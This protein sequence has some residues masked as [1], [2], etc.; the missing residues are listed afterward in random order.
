M[1][2]LGESLGGD[3]SQ[4]DN[5]FDHLDAQDQLNAEYGAELGDI[6]AEIAAKK[7]QDRELGRQAMAA[8]A[9]AP[10]E[11]A[12][13][14][15]RIPAADPDQ[16]RAAAA[17]EEAAGVPMPEAPLSSQVSNV[18]EALTNP[19]AQRATDAQLAREYGEIKD[20][21]PTSPSDADNTGEPTGPTP[22][23]IAGVEGPTG[24]RRA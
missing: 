23:G 21:K 20:G 2:I 14:V 24:Q 15:T 13:Q 7:E 4:N 9:A 12:P 10:A 1:P 6:D 11:S 22:G 17:A 3:Y 19:D 18:D 16:I 8:P 5:E